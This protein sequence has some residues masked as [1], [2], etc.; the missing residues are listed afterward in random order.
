MKKMKLISLCLF[1]S[2]LCFFHVSSN[3][4][5][6]EI[7]IYDNIADSH[8]SQALGIAGEDNE[9]EHGT[10]A[11]QMYDYEGMYYNNMTETLSIVGG[12]DV[13]HGNAG[14]YMGDIFVGQNLVFDFERNNMGGIWFDGYF[15]IIQD[16]TSFIPTSYLPESNPYQYND[17]GTVIGDGRYHVDFYFEDD[18]PPE[19][20]VTGWDGYY[21][22]WVV[23]LI[24]DS[25][26][27]DVVK[28]GDLI[29]LT[30][31]C[32]NDTIH[33]SMP[34]KR[35]PVP[36]PATMFLIGIGLLGIGNIRRKKNRIT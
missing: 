13:I 5:A 10:I 16:Y 26:F 2:I 7:T 34:T 23:S 3:V 4:Y 33:G 1:F 25:I 17:G 14:V 29:H 22:H 27:N 11:S 19:F 20:D 15:D 9:T 32:G 12:F 31:T 35:E 36:E 8:A 6:N 21:D 18:L 24:G 28:S 30:M